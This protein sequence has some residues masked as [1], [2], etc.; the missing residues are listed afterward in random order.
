LTSKGFTLAELLIALG[1]LGII[2][3]FAIPKI[4]NAQQ[5]EKSNAVAK[6]TIGAI[7]TA[8]QNYKLAHP[9]ANPTST[10]AIDIAQYLNYLFVDTTS[11]LDATE[12]NTDYPCV[13]AEPCYRLHNG[14]VLL[15]TYSNFCDTSSHTFLSFLLDP[16]GVYSGDITGPSKSIRINL[17]YNGRI[18]DSA[19]QDPADTICD[20]G[21]TSQKGWG[22]DPDSTWFYY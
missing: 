8:Y 15:A 12:Q 21:T 14:S 19:A 1:V 9:S 11:D 5:A 3:T 2:A 4:L 22:A 13:S 20:G 17:Y 18:I 10:T 7:A 6:E 16:D